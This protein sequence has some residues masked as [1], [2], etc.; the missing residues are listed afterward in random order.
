VTAP[1]RLA[2]VSGGVRSGKSVLAEQLARDVGGED[3]VYWATQAA[4]DDEMRA[5]VAVHRARRPAGWRTVEA[6][7]GDLA[8]LQLPNGRALLVDCL[9]GLISQV[10]MAN[11]H[12]GEAAAAAAR[13]AV[14]GLLAAIRAFDGPVVVVTNE[15]GWGVVPAFP[16]GRWFR[17]ALGEAGAR[18]AAEADL[19]VLTALG[20]PLVLKGNL[21]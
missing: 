12:D 11:E 8:A 15:V 14:D 6:G 4:A 19:V 9:G 13:R 5:R 16:L 18:L 21:P 20:L 10:I 3:V 17:D 7:P 1:F 2:I